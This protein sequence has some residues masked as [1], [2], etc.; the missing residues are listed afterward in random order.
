MIK[1]RNEFLKTIITSNS[2]G[3]RVQKCQKLAFKYVPFLAEFS[4][5]LSF[6]I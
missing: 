5:V 4:L 6:S 2:R 1:E 3:A